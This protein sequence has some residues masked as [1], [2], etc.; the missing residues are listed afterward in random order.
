MLDAVAGFEVRVAAT[1]LAA[2][3]PSCRL[4]L[5]TFPVRDEA[6]DVSGRA[7]RVVRETGACVVEEKG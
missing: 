6:Q 2:L 7:D 4:E 1:R 5:P 3:R